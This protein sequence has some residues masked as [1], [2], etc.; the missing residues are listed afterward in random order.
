MSAPLGTCL[1]QGN[2]NISDQS[3]QGALN[4]ADRAASSNVTSMARS[5]LSNSSAFSPKNI[6][7]RGSV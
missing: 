3:C 7:A 4:P 5:I 2:L 1:Q 6:A